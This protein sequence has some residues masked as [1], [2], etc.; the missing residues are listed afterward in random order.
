[1]AEKPTTAPT[2]A[3]RCLKC[4]WHHLDDVACSPATEALDA[5]NAMLREQLAWCM[6][7]LSHQRYRDALVAFL[8]ERGILMVAPARDTHGSVASG[9]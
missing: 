4:G 1:M 6:P 5:E 9:Q 7:R 3:V 8:A 2:H